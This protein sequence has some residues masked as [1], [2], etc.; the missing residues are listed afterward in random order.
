MGIEHQV[1]R[2]DDDVGNLERRVRELEN[3]VGKLVKTHPMKLKN[4]ASSW[5]YDYEDESTCKDLINIYKYQPNGDKE[6]KLISL[7]AIEMFR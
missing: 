7:D 2:I 6:K 3:I 4:D 1:D 5:H